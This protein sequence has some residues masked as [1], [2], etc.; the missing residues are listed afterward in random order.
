[1]SQREMFCPS[2]QCVAEVGVDANGWTIQPPGWCGAILHL[3]SDRKLLALADNLYCLGQALQLEHVIAPAERA[4]LGSMSTWTSE[5][6]VARRIFCKSC[7]E[8]VQAA[9]PPRG[10]IST[11]T[12]DANSKRYW[13]GTFCSRE[14]AVHDCERELLRWMEAA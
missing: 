3:D 5:G 12:Y 2:C 6:K 7:R 1:M 9:D 11:F 8:T 14:C 4:Q 10:W 13:T